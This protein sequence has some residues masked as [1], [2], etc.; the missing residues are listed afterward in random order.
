MKRFSII[1]AE[2]IQIIQL[3]ITEVT[4]LY[5]RVLYPLPLR[6]SRDGR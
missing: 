6:K 2:Y 1:L 5:H 4:T 3:N